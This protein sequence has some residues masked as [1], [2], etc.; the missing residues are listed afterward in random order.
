MAHQKRRATLTSGT[1]STHFSPLIKHFSPLLSFAAHSFA[2]QLSYLH[3]VFSFAHFPSSLKVFLHNAIRFTTL[4]L[5]IKKKAPHALESQ[6][7]AFITRK[8]TDL[9]RPPPEAAA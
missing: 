7:N 5:Q 8:I 9:H 2:A 4:R 6:Q 1:L 3:K